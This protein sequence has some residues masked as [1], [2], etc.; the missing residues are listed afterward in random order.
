MGARF[1]DFEQ[2]NLSD[3]DDTY[4]L[5]TDE[6]D[7][8]LL[9]Y[10]LDGGASSGDTLAASS[11]NDFE[12]SKFI[13]LTNTISGFEILGLSSNDDIWIASDNDDAIVG[14]YIDGRGGDD[15]H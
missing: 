15:R 8:G 5:S 9:G 2:V 12:I 4:E 1:Q 6:F 3:S 13:A 10:R 7:N 14:A 11:I